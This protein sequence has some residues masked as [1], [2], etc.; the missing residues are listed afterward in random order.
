MVDVPL[1]FFNADFIL[2]NGSL[3]TVAEK[4]LAGERL[5]LAPSY[6]V[7]AESVMP[8]LASRIDD[9]SASVAVPPREMA[10]SGRSV[11]WLPATSSAP[12]SSTVPGA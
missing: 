10:P 7:A 12:I 6:C 2:A 3:K 1:I 11:G 4:L 5:I 8:W 9:E